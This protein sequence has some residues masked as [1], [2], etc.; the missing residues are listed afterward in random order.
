MNSCSISAVA[1]ACSAAS[2]PLPRHRCRVPR[3]RLYPATGRGADCAGRPLA[4]PGAVAVTVPTRSPCRLHWRLL[5]CPVTRWPAEVLA[6]LESF[7]LRHLGEL[8]SLAGRRLRRRIGNGPLDDLSRAW[9]SCLIRKRHLFFRNNLRPAG[10]AITR[11]ACRSADFRRAAPVFHAGG[12]LHTASSAY[13][14]A[15]CILHDDGAWSAVPLHFAE[16]S[17]EEGRFLRLLR[18]HLGRL[19][20]RA[21]SRPAPAGRRTGRPADRQRPSV[22]AEAPSGEGRWFAWSACAPAWAS[23]PS[24][25]WRWWP[26][27][28]GVCDARAGSAARYRAFAAGDGASRPTAPALVAAHPQPCM[29]RAVARWHGPLRLLSPPERLESGWWDAGERQATGDVR[30]DYFAARNPLGQW[31][32]IFAAP[33]GGSCT[34]CSPEGGMDSAPDYAELHCLQF[35]FPARASHPMNWSSRQW[36]RAT[37]PWP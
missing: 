18:E 11:R 7:G 1:C 5:P 29:N 13:A 32:W 22:R 37:P 31:V 23:R 3:A 25:P 2:T 34:A 4:G 15:P 24:G 36:P 10:V 35:Q 16:A 33:K 19:T 9:A 21:R 27:T 20:L 6:R 26:I 12:W 28:A 30:R 17:A 8:R 14:A